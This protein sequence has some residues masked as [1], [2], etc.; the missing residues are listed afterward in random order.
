MKLH[1]S[2]KIKITENETGKNVPHLEIN[3]VVLATCN[4]VNNDY[5]QDSRVLHAFFPNKLFD[6]LIDVSPKNL[7][8]QKSL[9]QNFHIWKY[10]L[11]IKILNHWA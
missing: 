6:Q 3:E 5:Q 11:L 4:I 1:E 7:Y 8:F 9:I 10:S 2:T